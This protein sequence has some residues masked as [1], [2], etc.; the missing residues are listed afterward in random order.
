M[1]RQEVGQYYKLSIG[2]A[3]SPE[4]FTPIAC[5]TKLEFATSTN[6][7][8][9]TSNCGPASQPGFSK[10]TLNLSAYVD[11]NADVDGN[12]SGPGVY[13]LQIAATKFNFRIEP[14]A[15]P[16]TGDQLITGYAFVADYK[17]N[18]STDTIIGFDFTLNQVSGNFTQTIHA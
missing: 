9:G 7:I 5:I 2:D 11:Y 4:V 1:N 17:Q 6:V 10:S 13:E 18:L 14:I 12:I 15:T 16:A 8:D 3:G